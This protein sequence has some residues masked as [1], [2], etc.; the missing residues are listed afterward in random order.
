VLASSSKELSS[1]RAVA[2][3]VP[4]PLEI[5]AQQ[6]AWLTGWHVVVLLQIIDAFMVYALLTAAAQVRSLPTF[7]RVRLQTALGQALVGISK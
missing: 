5:T 1:N 3:A 6:Q 7:A 2:A 4:Q